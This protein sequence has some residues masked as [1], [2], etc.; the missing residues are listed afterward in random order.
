MQVK[1]SITGQYLSQ[2]KYIP[3]PQ[4]RKKGNG[5]YLEIVK[6]SEN[7]LKDVSVKFKLG[8][9]N[10]VTGVSGSGKST[11]VNEILY[12][13]IPLSPILLHVFA[14]FSVRHTPYNPQ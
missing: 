1:E 3:L 6:A 14:Y 11:L 8:C 12:K 10:V 5:K 13:S 9:F 2:E 4:K 7:N